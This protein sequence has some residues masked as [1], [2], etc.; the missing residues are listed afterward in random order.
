MADTTRLSLAYDLICSDTE[1]LGQ[2]DLLA[3]Y[4]PMEDDEETVVVFDRDGT[5]AD[6][7]SQRASLHLAN[8]T[9]WAVEEVE[10]IYF[11]SEGISPTI[12]ADS[13][14]AAEFCR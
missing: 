8:A 5:D 6:P 13:G 2:D 9:E 4:H 10:N 3:M 14:P 7:R 1:V 12:T 11:A